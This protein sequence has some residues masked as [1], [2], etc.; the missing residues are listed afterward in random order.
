M[1]YVL[2]IVTAYYYRQWCE[3]WKPGSQNSENSENRAIGGTPSTVEFSPT[4]TT[5]SC[6]IR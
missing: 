1:Y 2:C 5:G 4:T 3:W 6:I